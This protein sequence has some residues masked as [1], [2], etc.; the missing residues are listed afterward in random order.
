M[1]IGLSRTRLTTRHTFG[2]GASSTGSVPKYA[3]GSPS[4]NQPCTLSSPKIHLFRSD[5]T[6]MPPGILHHYTS[7]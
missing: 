4:R 1:C 2:I 5:V 7:H 6:T 3:H